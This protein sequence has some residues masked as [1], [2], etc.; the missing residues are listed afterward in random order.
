MKALIMLLILS[1]TICAYAD[2]N[3]VRVKA[4]GDI[5]HREIPNFK[6]GNG[7]KNA[8]HFNPE[9]SAEELEE[10]L[11]SKEDFD[12]SVQDDIDKIKQEEN[13]KIDNIK[14]VLPNLTDKEIKKLRDNLK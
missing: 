3:A 2:G 12:A 13:E 5:I 14:E 7:L 10:V 4:T 11:L 9:Y 1:V 8:V 6:T